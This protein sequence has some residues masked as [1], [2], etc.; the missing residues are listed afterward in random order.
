MLDTVQ[1]FDYSIKYWPGAYNAVADV[2]SCHPDHMPL[3]GDTTRA[4]MLE[5]DMQD[6]VEAGASWVEEMVDRYKLDSYFNPIQSW[7]RQEAAG[8]ERKVLVEEWGVLI[9][10]R[11]RRF[12]IEASSGLLWT[13]KRQICIP[14]GG[15]LRYQLF[16]KAHDTEAVGHFGVSHTYNSLSKRF[17]W[18][19]MMALVKAYVK[20]CDTC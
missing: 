9:E 13:E 11:K 14:R 18:P 8:V 5:L 6:T 19:R 7:L 1:H 17:F 10:A 16:H 12:K 15:G 4:D 3:E 2:L 20:T